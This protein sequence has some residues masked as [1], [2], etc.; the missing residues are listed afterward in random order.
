MLKPLALNNKIVELEKRLSFFIEF[1]SD[2]FN[3][4]IF[5]TSIPC[6]VKDLNG[7][8]LN[9]NQSFSS[10]IVGLDKETIVGQSIYSLFSK[11]ALKCLDFYS[12]K[13]A[14]FFTKPKQ[15]ASE[16]KIKCANEIEKYYLLF[17][18]SFT[19]KN[20]VVGIMGI[21]IDISTYNQAIKELDEVNAVLNHLAKA[22]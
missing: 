5:L 21:M 9:C 7:V 20:K 22:S 19:I 4:L 1:D 15:H 11:S 6:F 13:E 2:I 3:E 12:A 18:S 14:D 16:W 10:T 17:R 8:Y